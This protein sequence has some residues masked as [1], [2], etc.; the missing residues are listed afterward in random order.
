L[1]GTTFG[2]TGIFYYQ[3]L[4]TLDA[5]MAII[6]LFQFVWIGTI[7]DFLFN[8]KKPSPAK[9]ISII[10][11]IAGSL[12]A[13]NIFTSSTQA[14]T[15][16][17]AV[18]GFLSSISYTTSM[19]FSSKMENEL[20]AVQKSAFLTTGALLMIF[21]VFPPV[22]FTNVSLITGIFPY[23]L[24]LGFFGVFLPPLLYSI[25]LPHI[26]PSLGTMLSSSELPVAVIMS[27]TVL[28]E[29]VNTPQWFG[30]LLILA[31][32][33]SGNLFSGKN[34]KSSSESSLPKPACEKI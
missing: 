24:L 9:I 14:I 29:P 13:A 25:G 34:S 21:L 12:L 33:L 2:M 30:V 20:P 26:G 19:F 6:F 22:A 1:A 10:I 4:K 32:I 8:K 15:L 31:G 5:S 18:W 17:G 23:A 3:S 27:F 16:S 11:L 28:K 7:F